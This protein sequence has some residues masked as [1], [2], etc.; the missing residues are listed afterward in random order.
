MLA[1][2]VLGHRGGDRP[3]MD[4]EAAGPGLLSDGADRALSRARPSTA[5]GGWRWRW[6]SRSCGAPCSTASPRT[7]ST[8][9]SAARRSG[10]RLRR[11]GG[12]A[13]DREP[14]DGDGRRRHRPTAPGRPATPPPY[15]ARIRLDEVNAA[16]RAAWAAPGRLVHV[17]HDRRDRGRRGAAGRGLGGERAARRSRLSRA[18]R[19]GARS[20]Q[21]ALVGHGQRVE[22]ARRRGRIVDPFAQRGPPLM[23]SMA[24]LSSSYS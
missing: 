20:A 19:A 2:R 1:A 11:A 7:S 8:S 13:D 24:S 4:A 16:F 12:S 5:T 18:G 21:A 15:L 17:A 3:F 6:P 22:I 10:W 23:T 9:R 14:A